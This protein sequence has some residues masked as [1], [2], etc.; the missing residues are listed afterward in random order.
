[1]APGVSY[2]DLLNV[3]QGTNLY[4]SLGLS[5][6]ATQ[7]QVKAAYRRL[8]KLWD[9]D[10]NTHD[11]TAAH[12][13]KAMEVAHMVLGD[14]EARVR[15]VAGAYP[16]RVRLERVRGQWRRRRRRRRGRPHDPAGDPPHASR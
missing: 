9:P 10:M 3:C 8:S 4:E 6:D 7:S 14:P 5:R 2:T 1:M 13:A 11:P 15:A 12:R 16:D